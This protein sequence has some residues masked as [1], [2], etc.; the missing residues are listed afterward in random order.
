VT[1]QV[2]R[3]WRKK[4]RLPGRLDHAVLVALGVLAHIELAPRS[5][6]VP[7]V[8]TTLP[9]KTLVCCSSS[10]RSASASMFMGLARSAF[11]AWPCPSLLPGPP[12]QEGGVCVSW[13]ARIL[14]PL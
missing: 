4:A 14:H 2:S 8:I 6:M 5:T 1:G 7:L 12:A 13:K 11:S 9:V 3:F 10:W